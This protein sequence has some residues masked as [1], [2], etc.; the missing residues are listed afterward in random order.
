MIMVLGTKFL[1]KPWL[2]RSLK[3]LHYACT[4]FRTYMTELYEKEK[5]SDRKSS[6]RNLMTS[7]VRASQEEN[8]SLNESEIYGNSGHL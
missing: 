8:G 2:P 6:D 4:A 1:A 7:L 5:Q 3:D